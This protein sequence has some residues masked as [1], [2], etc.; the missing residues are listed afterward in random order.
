MPPPSL[1]HTVERFLL[2]KQRFLGG[3][4]DANGNATDAAGMRQLRN[5]PEDDDGVTE[6][7]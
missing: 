6:Y 3:K 4:I 2:S 1:F 5:A 7:R